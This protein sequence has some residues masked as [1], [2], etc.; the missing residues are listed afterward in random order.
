MTRA[1][2]QQT[3]LGALGAKVET[4][5]AVVGYHSTDGRVRVRMADGDKVDAELL[6]GA[7]GLHSA[8]RRAM[9]GD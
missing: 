7:D 2:L 6:V 5:R 9:R 8:V 4:G 1:D 3:L